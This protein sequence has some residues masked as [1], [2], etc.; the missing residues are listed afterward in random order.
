MLYFQ[1]F[2]ATT[3]FNSPIFGRECPQNGLVMEETPVSTSKR[4]F[5]RLFSVFLLLL[6]MH[7]GKTNARRIPR[8]R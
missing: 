8:K 3:D 6:T 1:L 2:S 4:E 7:G 5:R